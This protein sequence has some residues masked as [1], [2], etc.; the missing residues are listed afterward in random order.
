MPALKFQNSN[1]RDVLNTIGTSTGIGVQ[2]DQGLEG[3]L[4][5]P[6]SVDLAGHSLES[7]FNMVLSQNTLTYKI[8]D[9]HTIFIY[10]DNQQQRT[11]YEDVSTSRRSTCRTVT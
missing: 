11:K 5:Q 8:L 7:A 6:F 10:Q 2:Y 9:S 3:T 1:I 4:S